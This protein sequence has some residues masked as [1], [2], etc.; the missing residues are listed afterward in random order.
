M[1]KVIKKAGWKGAAKLLGKGALSI[2]LKG[3]GVG[4]LAS[5]ALDATTIYSIY[6]MITSED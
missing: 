3:T 2:G 6:S 4:A 5:L 1:K